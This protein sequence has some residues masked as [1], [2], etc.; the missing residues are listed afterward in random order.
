MS[1]LPLHDEGAIHMIHHLKI[2]EFTVAIA[3]ELA[4]TVA[5]VTITGTIIYT[6]LLV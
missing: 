4:S 2:H 6:C 1:S 5:M 3:T